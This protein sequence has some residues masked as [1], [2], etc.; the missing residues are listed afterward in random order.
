MQRRPAE[1]SS[2]SAPPIRSERFL[3]FLFQTVRSRPDRPLTA[4][5]AGR[6]AVPA[7]LALALGAIGCHSP[8]GPMRTLADA[9]ATAANAFAKINPLAREE[10]AETPAGTVETAVD[11]FGAAEAA[12]A[13]AEAAQPDAGAAEPGTTAEAE[14]VEVAGTEQPQF[15][16]DFDAMIAVL[17]DE[18]TPFPAP[19]PTVTEKM[20]MSAAEGDEAASTAAAAAAE[21]A[22]P[23]AGSLA[24]TLGET[25]QELAEAPVP[26]A[27][28]ADAPVKPADLFDGAPVGPQDLFADA[29]S[30]PNETA[31]SLGD[32]LADSAPPAGRAV[33]DEMPAASPPIDPNVGAVVTASS[34]DQTGDPQA[35]DPL[36][37]GGAPIFADGEVPSPPSAAPMPPAL[38]A[39][40]LFPPSEGETEPREGA[41]TVSANVGT[42][43]LGGAG[44]RP[45]ASP[46]PG[47][48]IGPQPE[49]SFGRPPLPGGVAEP[50]EPRLIRP[51]DPATDSATGSNEKPVDPA[52]MALAGPGDSFGGTEDA[53]GPPAGDG[54][55]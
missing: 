5:I 11:P 46:A 53:F 24:G 38:S 13:R 36:D 21:A 23:F 22:D 47:P 43:P 42:A 27:E 54:T 48:M 29:A 1:P 37:G 30:A 50:N 52:W 18:A 6:A 8:A 51:D 34:Q 17:R 10:I 20:A 41:G 55:A 45:A 26:P 19:P 16:G 25:I 39:A 2:S 28:L 9:R 4:R 7:A 12:L 40:D 14:P 31:T 44:E 49:L 15:A 33:P 3:Q 35:G 32:A